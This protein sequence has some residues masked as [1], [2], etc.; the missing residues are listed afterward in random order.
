MLDVRVRALPQSP[1]ISV[2]SREHGSTRCSDCKDLGVFG[3]AK[4]RDH[5][6]KPWPAIRQV[7]RCRPSICWAEDGGRCHVNVLVVVR[8]KGCEIGAR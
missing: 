2:R 1:A 5:S 4:A 8:R 3:L 7:A 6:G